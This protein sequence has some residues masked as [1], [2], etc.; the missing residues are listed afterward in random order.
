MMGIITP[1]HTRNHI[2][3]LLLDVDGHEFFE[4]EYDDEAR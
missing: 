4:F 1:A 3:P 2:T